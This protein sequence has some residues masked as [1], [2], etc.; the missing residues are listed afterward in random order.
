[1]F[2]STLR[3]KPDAADSFDASE[4][5][6]FLA[7]FYTARA[8][9]LGLV[10]LVIWAVCAW[11]VYRAHW[12][13]DL[14]ALWFA[15]HFHALGQDGLIY[16][17]PPQFFG[18][19]PDEWRA[20]LAQTRQ[21]VQD[22]A[23]PYIYPPLWLAFLAPLTKA[24]SPQGFQAFFLSLHI[25]MLFASVLLA[26]QIARPAKMPRIVFRLWGLA[27]LKL[28]A[29]IAAALWLNQPSII[30]A[31]LI[32]LA[33]ALMV[34]RPALSGAAIALA[35]AIKLTPVVFAAVYFML[36]R[37]N[38]AQRKRALIAVLFSGAILAGLSIALLGWPLHRAFL[39][40]L[41]LAS[42]KSVWA[43]V[44]PSARILIQD[45]AGIIGLST[46]L[47]VPTPLPNMLLVIPPLW[48]SLVIGGLG[49]VLGVFALRIAA[50]RHTAP[51]R[52]L[53]LLGLSIG[54]FLFGPLSW[55]HYLIV[56]LLLAPAV[57]AGLSRWAGGAILAL[58]LIGN[59]NQVLSIFALSGLH[60]LPY[61]VLMVTIWA[62][63]LGVTYHA[64]A[65]QPRD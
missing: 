38:A 51:A 19:I 5:H 65:K 33:G 43:A 30:V 23:F 1:M 27:T 9:R 12:G 59:S 41:H 36:P 48:T 63:V 57:C 44:N 47:N 42:G 64:L 21:N 37:E 50:R 7:F 40:Q 22:N 10:L 55:L 8:D 6:R 29:P 20:L 62:I 54:L 49:F 46:P 52:A 16:V 53:A 2:Q 24:F 3:S 13:N 56:P 18:G 11:F 15:G 25:V 31:F 17:A 45:L 39:D 4:R 28:T 61:T 60:L 34:K 32:L 35:S 26:E 14:A 58:I